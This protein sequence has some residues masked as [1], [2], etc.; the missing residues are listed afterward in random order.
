MAEHSE[1]C[2]VLRDE[3]GAIVPDTAV[4]VWS[5]SAATTLA[6]LYTTRSGTLTYAN[7][8]SSD[9]DGILRCFV[10]DPRLW[11][12]T[13]TQTTPLPLFVSQAGVISMFAAASAPGTGAHLKGEVCWNSSPDST[14]DVGWVCTVSGSPGTWKSFGMVAV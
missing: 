5:D 13:A 8:L 2:V 11:Y 10:E 7:P 9:S 6:T 1:L 3:T 4:S 12:T 14:E